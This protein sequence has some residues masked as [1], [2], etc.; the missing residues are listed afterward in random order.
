MWYILR[1]LIYKRYVDRL[2]D[3]LH[4][5]VCITMKILEILVPKREYSGKTCQ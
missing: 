4:I 2:I 3:Y 1:K 5:F